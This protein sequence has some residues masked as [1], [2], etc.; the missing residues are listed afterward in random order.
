MNRLTIAID[1]IQ[2]ARNYTLRLINEVPTSQWYLIPPAGVSHIAWQ[3]GH[4]AMAQY[5]LAIDRIRG[6]LPEDEKL[7]PAEFFRVFG[8]GTQPQAEES[9][10]PTVSEIR[11]VLDAVH[12]QMMLELTV[13]H[14]ADLD[15]PPI[16]PH[17]LFN[18]KI[19]SLYWT[20]EHEMLHAGQIGLLRR[21]LGAPALW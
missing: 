13:A 14:D 10:Y 8:K 11:R 19:D 5:R 16:K 18:R 4:I 7:I 6:E 12:R 1:R 20:A 3:V 21:Q 15:A 17:P 9:L 2:F